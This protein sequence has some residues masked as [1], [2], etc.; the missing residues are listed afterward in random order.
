MTLVVALLLFVITA[1]L[2]ISTRITLAKTISDG[3]KI[4]QNSTQ[5]AQ[6]SSSPDT[7][8]ALQETKEQATAAQQEVTQPSQEANR[9]LDDI[10]NLLS[11]FNDLTNKDLLTLFYTV[12]TTIVFA[13]GIKL[14]ADV[15]MKAKESEKKVDEAT[16]KAQLLYNNSFLASFHAKLM[17]PYIVSIDLSKQTD[18]EAHA[19]RVRTVFENL[20][21]CSGETNGGEGLFSVAEIRKAG[22]MPAETKAGARKL[23]SN[24]IDNLSKP[25]SAVVTAMPTEKTIKKSVAIC[26][27]YIHALC[28]DS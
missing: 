20:G 6:V 16:K 15:Q 28:E 14:F 11:E 13:W 2:A 19:D 24:I 9:Q 10:A 12:V 7:T 22:S 25:N 1:I 23:L 3:I 26:E 27:D 4:A 8:I 21:D 5:S 18:A 17:A